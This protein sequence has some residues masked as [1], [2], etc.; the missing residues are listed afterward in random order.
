MDKNYENQGEVA[1]HG[2]PQTWENI[3][4]LLNLKNTNEAF[5]KR[6]KKTKDW[7]L[8]HERGMCVCRKM[9]VLGNQMIWKTPF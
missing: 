8:V 3:F 4:E 7:A 9:R 5:Q 2:I 6:K 1:C